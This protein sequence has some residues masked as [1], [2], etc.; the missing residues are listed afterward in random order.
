MFAAS[1]TSERSRARGPASLFIGVAHP[2]D[3]FYLKCYRTTLKFIPDLT[4]HLRGLAFFTRFFYF[5]A[6]ILKRS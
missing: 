6:N 1:I 4:R 5:S 2:P 3:K